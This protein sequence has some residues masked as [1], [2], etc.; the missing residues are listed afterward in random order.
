[1][2]SPTKTS[3]STEPLPVAFSELRKILL[4]GSPGEKYHASNLLASSTSADPASAY[5]ACTDNNSA[6]R[7][8]GA[9][10]LGRAQCNEPEAVSLLVGLLEDSSGEVRAKAAFALSQIK[11]LAQNSPLS[12][13]FCKKHP[14]EH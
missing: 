5:E 3:T 1:M 6:I 4:S 7:E 8:T 2:S 10:A 12:E 13:D 9:W 11:G 14:N